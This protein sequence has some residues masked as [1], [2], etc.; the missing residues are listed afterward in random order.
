MNIVMLASFLLGW[1]LII[2]LS[3]YF[4]RKFN[5]SYKEAGKKADTFL[6]YYF[7]LITVIAIIFV[8]VTYS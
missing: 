8:T 4:K 5:L 1:V 7:L 2:T 3:I 6:V